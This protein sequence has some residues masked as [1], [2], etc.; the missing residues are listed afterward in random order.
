MGVKIGCF[1][2]LY[3]YIYDTRYHIWNTCMIYPTVLLSMILSDF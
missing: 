2:P 1:Q 3:G